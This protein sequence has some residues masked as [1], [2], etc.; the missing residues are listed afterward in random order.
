M[1]AKPFTVAEFNRFLKVCSALDKIA[2]DV[3]TDLLI[4]HDK[5]HLTDDWH[6]AKGDKLTLDDEVVP[7]DSAVFV[8]GKVMVSLGLPLAD[9]IKL[10]D[11]IKALNLKKGR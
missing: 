8:D 4:G 1:S 7:E 2:I 3:E 6:C 9:A 11:F 10:V 5:T